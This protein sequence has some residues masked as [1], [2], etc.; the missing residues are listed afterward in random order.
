MRA[1]IR[2]AVTLDTVFFFPYRNINCDATLLIC[3]RAWWSRSIYIILECWYWK[4]I[5]FLSINLSLDILNEINN[6]FSSTLN[7]WWEQSFVFAWFPRIWNLNFNN[8]LSACVDSVIVHLYDLI[9]LSSVSSLSCFLHKVDCFFFR[10]DGRQFEECWLKYRIDTSAK[11]DLFTDLDTI[12]RIELDVVIR[13]KCLYLSWQMLIKTFHIP[14]AVQKECSSVYQFLY[15]IVLVYIR[16]IMA[17]N[18]VCFMDQICWF[19]RFLT[20]TQ[21]RHC[22]TAWL[23]G[24]IVKVSLCIHISVVTNDLDR[25]LIRANSTICSKSPE[26]AVDRSFW[27]RNK[28]SADFK[29]KICH[30]IFDTD[31]ESSLL[32]VIKYC[33]DLCRRRIFGS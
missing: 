5:S 16:R 1:Y 29:R 19:D 13:D 23:L 32:C 33:N 18:K 3:G 31:R 24:V 10:N 14:W 12:D 4:R 7:F 27:S 2:T 11:S 8:L 20:K 15:H 26:L 25:V 6:I 28:R 9:S 17:C 30:V 22:N 21:V